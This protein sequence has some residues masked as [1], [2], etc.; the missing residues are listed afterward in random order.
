MTASV[1]KHKEKQVRKDMLECS[2]LTEQDDLHIMESDTI[3]YNKK[4]DDRSKLQYL[5][6]APVV[7]E[8]RKKRY[9]PEGCSVITDS[10]DDRTIKSFIV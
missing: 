9:E 10:R 6:T 7:D 5:F 3:K 4:H 2:A 1:Q 8:Y